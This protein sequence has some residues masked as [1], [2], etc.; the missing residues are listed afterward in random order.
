MVVGG[1]A[2]AA[3]EKAGVMARVRRQPKPPPPI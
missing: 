1:E 2:A 3:V